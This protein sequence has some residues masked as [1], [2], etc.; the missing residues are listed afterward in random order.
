M[1]KQRPLEELASSAKASFS[2][3]FTNTNVDGV[4]ARQGRA[5]TFIPSFC[6]G[7][8]EGDRRGLKGCN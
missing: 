8:R 5:G 1:I 6:V 4:T 2:T 7:A 3:R